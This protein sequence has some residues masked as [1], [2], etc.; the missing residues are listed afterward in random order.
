MYASVYLRE[1]VSPRMRAGL[2]DSVSLCQV[3]RLE[4]CALFVVHSPFFQGVFV[5]CVVSR[6]CSLPLIRLQALDLLDKMLTFHPDN[7]ITAE[8][9]LAHPFFDMFRGT[10]DERVA[11][12]PFSFA[13]ESTISSTNTLK[14]MFLREVRHHHQHRRAPV[15][16]NCLNLWTC[17]CGVYGACVRC[18][19][20]TAGGDCES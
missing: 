5:L 20:V 11:A 18:A 3:I 15:A 19:R 13:F 16:A 2:C 10:G 14:A 6:L 9:A 17:V 7:R 4:T 8:E 12:A 1:C